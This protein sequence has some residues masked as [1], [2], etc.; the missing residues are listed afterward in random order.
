MQETKSKTREAIVAAQQSEFRKK[1]DKEVSAARAIIGIVIGEHPE[2]ADTIARMAR[3][4]PIVKNYK[5][6][7]MTVE[8]KEDVKDFEIEKYSPFYSSYDPWNSIARI[9]GSIAASKGA[10]I[11][12][13]RRGDEPKPI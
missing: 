3:D 4:D 8:E 2:I 5:G 11:S 9:A 10:P 1:Y 6:K 7:K 12:T 13:F